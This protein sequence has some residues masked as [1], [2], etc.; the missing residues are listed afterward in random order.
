MIMAATAAEIKK[1]IEELEAKQALELEELKAQLRNT[2]SSLQPVNLIKSTIHEVVRAPEVK[3]DLLNAGLSLL[4]GYVAKKAVV[5]NP[6]SMLKKLLGDLL[7]LGVTASV[8]KHP[9]EIK[10]AVAKLVDLA[11]SLKEAGTRM[12]DGT[13]VRRRLMKEIMQLT[14]FIQSAHPQ[15][16]K[17]L[18]ETPL[19]EAGRD[20]QISIKSLKSYRDSLQLQLIQ[21]G[22]KTAVV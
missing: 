18:D 14:L 9:D 2:Y 8:A 4:A 21:F 17:I 16:Y 1:R 7:Q 22:D 12:A 15:L 20:N 10:A 6:D 3:E 13:A 11:W 19:P 5:G